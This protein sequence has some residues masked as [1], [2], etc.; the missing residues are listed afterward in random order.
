MNLLGCL[1]RPTSGC[2]ICDGV[3]TSTM[4]ID[5]LARIRNRKIG[6]V[7]QNFNLLPRVTALGNV[8]LPLVYSRVPRAARHRK[9]RQALHAVG[10]EERLDHLPSQLSGGQQQRVAIA[11]ALVNDPAIIFA[12]EPTGALDSHTGQDIMGL[13]QAL[14]TEG[15]TVVI[16]THEPEVAAYA[17]R[18]LRFKDGHLISDEQQAGYAPGGETGLAEAGKARP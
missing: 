16:V 12:D 10:L 1:D 14:N 13:L 6:F 2:Y 3:D 5:D 4:D 7:F 9:A 18:V 11:R 15:R 17:R 8:E